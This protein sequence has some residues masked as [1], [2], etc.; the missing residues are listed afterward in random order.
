MINLNDSY[1][2]SA[3]EDVDDMTHEETKVFLKAEGIDTTEL[4]NWFKKMVTTQE[5]IKN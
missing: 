5:D 2:G 1:V 3:P 4:I